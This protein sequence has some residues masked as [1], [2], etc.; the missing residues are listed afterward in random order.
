MSSINGLQTFETIKDDFVLSNPLD[1][2]FLLSF[3]LFLDF[4]VRKLLYLLLYTF[5]I[6]IYKVY[7]PELHSFLEVVRHFIAPYIKVFALGLPAK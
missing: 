3:K 7:L 4:L 2:P 1:T 5:L 6:L